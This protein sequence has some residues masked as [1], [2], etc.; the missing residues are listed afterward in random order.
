MLKGQ[1]SEFSDKRIPELW[2]VIK[3]RMENKKPTQIEGSLFSESLCRSRVNKISKF[4]N[5]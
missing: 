4:N 5:I 1:L 3:N 2:T